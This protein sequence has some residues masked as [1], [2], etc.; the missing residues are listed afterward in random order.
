MFPLPESVPIAIVPI[1]GVIPTGG[2]FQAPPFNNNRLGN[3]CALAWAG[4]VSRFLLVAGKIED[5]EK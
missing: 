3:R 5:E 1:Q 2:L 4:D